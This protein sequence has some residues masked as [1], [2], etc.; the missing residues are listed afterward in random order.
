MRVMVIVKG[1]PT[2]E[3][4]EMAGGEILEAM[5]RY[6]QELIDAG[7]MIDGAGVRPTKEGRRMLFDGDKRTVREGPFEPASEQLAGFWLWQVEDLDEAEAWLRKCP[8]PMLEASEVEFRPL[9]E[10]ED[11]E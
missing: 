5:G 9:Y 3:T 1:T 2:S 8:N 4:G 7:V 11:F 6:N 10:M